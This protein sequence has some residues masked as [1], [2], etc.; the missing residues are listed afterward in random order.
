M[1]KLIGEAALLRNVG[2]CGTAL[3][4]PSS[5]LGLGVALRSVGGD[6]GT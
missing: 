1:I 6:G 4:G 5:R 3:T 2:D